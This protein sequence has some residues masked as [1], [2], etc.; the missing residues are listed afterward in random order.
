MPSSLHDHNPWDAPDPEEDDISNAERWRPGGNQFGAD[1][2][3]R[4]DPLGTNIFEDMN[5]IMQRMSAPQGFP[6]PRLAGSMP[7]ERQPGRTNRVRSSSGD[8]PRGGP[9]VQTF[10]T[11]SV[12]PTASWSFTA[13]TSNQSPNFMFGSGA[14][15][16]GRPGP[17]SMQE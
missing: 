10:S 7:G 1:F 5:N 17:G 14:F 3:P 9:R 8:V 11:F 6:G 15:P 13:S 2:P 12:G 4:G 16:S